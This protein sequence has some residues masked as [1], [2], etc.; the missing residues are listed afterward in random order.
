MENLLETKTLVALGIDLPSGKGN[1]VLGFL[2]FTRCVLAELRLMGVQAE[3]AAA[4]PGDGTQS[5]FWVT[6]LEVVDVAGALS[7]LRQIGIEVGGVFEVGW[8]DSETGAWRT[9]Y[10][11]APGPAPFE[12][13]FSKEAIERSASAR[14]L[15]RNDLQ[16]ITRHE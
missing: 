11:S 3:Q 14:R 9:A 15:E 6:T 8:K 5:A 1:D 10:S 13:F 7:G 4:A 16:I 2:C 12:R